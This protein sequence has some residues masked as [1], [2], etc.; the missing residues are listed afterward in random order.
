MTPPA[1]T[2]VVYLLAMAGRIRTHDRSC[3]AVMVLTNLKHPS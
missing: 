3:R 2:D 1:A